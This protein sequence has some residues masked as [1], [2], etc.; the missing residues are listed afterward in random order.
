MNTRIAVLMGLTLLT[1]TACVRSLDP[2]CPASARAPRPDLDGTWFETNDQ[3]DIKQGDRW[4]FAGN[5][6]TTTNDEQKAG[7]LLEVAYFQAAGT[8][9]ADTTAAEMDSG[10]DGWW[11]MHTAPVHHVSR[12]ALDGDRLRVTPLD[13][14]WLKAAIRSTNSPAANIR[15]THDQQNLFAARP[16]A[17]VE[18]L[19]RV[20][21]D[22]NAFPPQRTM[23]LR[24]AAKTP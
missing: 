11:K 18:L 2:F 5:R 22:T 16:A 12:I 6:V 19:G 15:I 4:L 23:V 3:G 24:R 17:W 9:F 10:P 13:Q 21:A 8:W 14:D 1:A 20:A 7:G